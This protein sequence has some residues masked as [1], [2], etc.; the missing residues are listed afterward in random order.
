MIRLFFVV[1]VVL[2]IA[3]S[4]SAAVFEAKPIPQSMQRAMTDSGLWSA[5]CPVPLHR[6]LL[7]TISH[8]DFQGAVHHDGQMIVMDAAAPRLLRVFQTLYARKFP[9]KQMRLL[10]MYGGNDARSMAD[11]NTSAYNCREVTGGGLPSVHAYGLAIDVNTI[12][13]PYIGPHDT[14]KGMAEV[15][16]SAGLGFLNRT[17]QR[18]GMVEPVVDVFR[19]NGFPV[20]G[21]NWNDPIDWQHFQPPRAVAQLLTVMTPKHAQH[22][23][24]LYAK[25]PRML[26][27]VSYKTEGKEL[28]ALYRRNADQ[29]MSA[30]QQYARRMH[31]MEP[32]AAINFLETKL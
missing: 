11:N 3:P 14:T 4:A 28:A 8:V 10:D 24:D 20:W 16:P 19:A 13:N 21:G 18:S 30:Y 1:I 12:Q 5:K 15:Q 17:N 23:F 27:K 26:T 31:A 9:V 22:F 32:A 6:L 25:Y 2:C 29:F 7:L